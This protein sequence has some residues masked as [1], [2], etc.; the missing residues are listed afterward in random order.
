MVCASDGVEMILVAQRLEQNAQ[1]PPGEAMERPLHRKITT[2]IGLSGLSFAVVLTMSTIVGLLL[3]RQQVEAKAT[4]QLHSLAASF[5]QQVE[6][7]FLQID[8]L[9]LDARSEFK[10]EQD[11]T[12]ASLHRFLEGRMLGLPQGQALMIFAANGEMLAHS[13]EF[14]TPPINASDRAYFQAQQGAG[15]DALFVSEATRNRVNGRW[16]IGM[17][18]RLDNPDNASGG[19]MMAAVEIEYFLKLCD[20]LQLPDGVSILLL[21]KEDGK[22]LFAYP[23]QQERL[24]TL[25]SVSPA[26][27]SAAA[28][29]TTPAPLP[30][31]PLEVVAAMPMAVAL[32][33]WQTL[34]WSLGAATAVI[35]VVVAGLTF[36]LGLWAKRLNAQTERLAKLN[37]DLKRFAEILAHHIQE[38]VRLQMTF[39]L[40]LTKLLSNSPLPLEVQRSLDHIMRGAERLR[41]LLR[42]VQLYL[43]ISQSPGD[44]RPCDTERALR[45]A[46]NRLTAKLDERKAVIHHETLPKV[47]IDH[48]RLTDVFSALIENSLLH[49]REGV[50]PIL[51]IGAERQAGN[52][53][54]SIDDNGNQIPERFRNQV[55]DVFERL[56]PERTPLGTGIGLALVRRIIE[57]AGGK[58]WIKASGLGGTRVLLSLRGGEE[59]AHGE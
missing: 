47:I 7:A 45:E 51:R 43:A 10:L 33:D 17:S 39:A 36:L 54:I 9:L 34:A 13:R 25:F 56:N 46:L 32:A 5:A 42:D 4:R 26:A 15:R 27:G 11:K 44:P 1:P 21:R 30:T 37:Q 3:V 49:G 24:G 12:P 2:L 28:R 23:Q 8:R 52:V 40:R 22:I 29:I 35:V 50:A 38:P 18:R 31:L 58:V 59:T 57:T 19:V 53:V 16:M 55:F 20:G 48:E 41:A 14:P 6:G